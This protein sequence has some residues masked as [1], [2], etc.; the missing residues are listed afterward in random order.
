LDVVN[1]EAGLE[2]L[3]VIAPMLETDAVV[4]ESEADTAEPAA[5]STDCT[6]CI[7]LKPFLGCMSFCGE[8][9]TE[10]G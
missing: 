1:K 4:T 10:G 8:D 7:E 9:E 3:S 5:A 2:P 6:V